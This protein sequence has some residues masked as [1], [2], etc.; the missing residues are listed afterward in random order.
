LSRQDIEQLIAR[1]FPKPDVEGR[2]DPVASQSALPLDRNGH[3]QSGR[4]AES[5]GPETGAP[6]H[7]VKVEPLSASGYRVQFTASDEL[8]A[9]IEQAKELLSHGMPSGDLAQLFERAMDAL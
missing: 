5:I 3:V 4:P 7:P 2:I 8:Y 1:W 6:R 9:K